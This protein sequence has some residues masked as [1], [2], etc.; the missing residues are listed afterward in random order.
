MSRQLKALIA[1]LNEMTPSVINRTVHNE[2]I[3]ALTKLSATQSRSSDNVMSEHIVTILTL[4]PEY[5][6]NPSNKSFKNICQN[7]NP[8]ELQLSPQ[9]RQHF[10]NTDS[11]TLKP[12]VRKPK[13]QR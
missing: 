8:T 3:S 1:S 9:V 11:P 7:L 12:D 6:D 5:I 4:M 2:I 10:F 13:P